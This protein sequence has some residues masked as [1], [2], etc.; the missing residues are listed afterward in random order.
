MLGLVLCPLVLQWGLSR[1]TRRGLLLSQKESFL[2]VMISARL[3]GF[4]DCALL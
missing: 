3:L 1:S 4:L 2:R